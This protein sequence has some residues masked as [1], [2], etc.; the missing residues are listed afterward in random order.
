MPTPAIS[1]KT[2]TSSTK[3]TATTPTPA[4]GE[5]SEKTLYIV[6]GLLVFLIGCLIVVMCCRRTTGRHNNTSCF[7]YRGR[8]VKGEEQPLSIENNQ[9]VADEISDIPPGMV[10]LKGKRKCGK[11]S[12][13]EYW[14]GS[15][16]RG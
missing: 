13:T 9:R 11:E 14:R 5:T 4:T 6:I 16:M 2:T 8:E 10:S 3:R 15:S 12:T 7:G 1:T